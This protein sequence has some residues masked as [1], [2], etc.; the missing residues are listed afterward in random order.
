MIAPRDVFPRLFASY[1][2]GLFGTCTASGVFAWVALTRLHADARQLGLMLAIASLAAAFASLSLSSFVDRWPKRRTMVVTDVLCAVAVA[3]VVAALLLGHLTMAHLAAATAVE[4]GGGIVFT[5]AGVPLLKAIAA[6]RLDW[7]NGRMESAYWAAQTVGPAF[8]GLLTATLGPAATMAF[9]AVSFLGSA[10]CLVGMPTDGSLVR[11]WSEL[12]LRSALRP[13]A[14]MHTI[15]SDRRTALLFANAMVFGGAVTATTTLLPILVTRTLHLSAWEFGLILALPCLG[16]VAASTLSPRIVK[17]F[18][19][20]RTLVVAGVLRTIWIVPLAFIPHGPWAA[21]FIIGVETCFL[22]V[23][24]VFNPVFATTRMRL[25]PDWHL[26]AVVSTWGASTKLIQPFFILG[27]GLF[28]A[29]VG[30]TKAMFWAGVA[31]LASSSAFLLW[32]RV[33]SDATNS[34]PHAPAVRQASS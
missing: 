27:S 33:A 32:P 29:A 19:R 12:P 5:S 15:L 4:V 22:F 17:V 1:C 3:S 2:I 26:G 25:V 9:N 7:A 14:G 30:P 11:P 18:G 8:G 16:G 28:A 10:V 34:E 24:G 31:C 23:A 20:N 13:L 6:D 21:T